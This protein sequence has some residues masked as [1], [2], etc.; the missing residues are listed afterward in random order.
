[1]LIIISKKINIPLI[2]VKELD[3]SKTI[4]CNLN[5]LTLWWWWW[6]CKEETLWWVEW[7]LEEWDLWDQWP[8]PV[9]ELLSKE[10]TE[11]TIIKIIEDNKTEDNPNKLLLKL[12]TNSLKKKW[13]SKV[14]KITSVIS[15]KW[16][17]IS[18]LLFWENSCTLWSKN[19]LKT[20]LFLLKS[21]EC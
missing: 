8:N 19:S 16:K 7:D 12:L 4:R 6:W 1:M 17:K 15:L 13:P 21:Q 5:S 9:K 20:K 18:N 11:E 10:I 14:L 3:N 2:N